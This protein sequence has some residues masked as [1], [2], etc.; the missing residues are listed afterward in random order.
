M[1]SEREKQM[2]V[3]IIDKLLVLGTTTQDWQYRK[4]AELATAAIHHVIV[5]EDDEE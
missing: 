3:D 5:G 4:A 1:A 2:L